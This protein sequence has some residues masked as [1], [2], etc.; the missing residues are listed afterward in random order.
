[1]S[2]HNMD[3]LTDVEENIVAVQL[4][5]SV[6][7]CSLCSSHLLLHTGAM[8]A[9][10]LDTLLLSC[11]PCQVF[12]FT[13]EM[14]VNEA[15]STLVDNID[16]SVSKCEDYIIPI[17]VGTDF[18]LLSGIVQHEVLEVIATKHVPSTFGGYSISSQFV[19]IATHTR[20]ISHPRVLRMLDKF[21][22]SMSLQNA[23]RRVAISLQECQSLVTGRQLLANVHTHLKIEHFI[24][25][26]VVAIRTHADVKLGP[27]PCSTEACIQ[28]AKAVAVLSEFNFVAPMHVIAVVFEV[29]AHRFALKDL[30]P[31]FEE[32]LVSHSAVSAEKKRILQEV[33][34]I[35]P[36]P[37]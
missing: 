28:A 8:N 17:V 29:L 27:S 4:R 6:D 18:D 16:Q 11:F 26:I 2:P 3:D 36:A 1:M 21:L 13:S 33:L 25:D 5:Q 23:E 35:A 31:D 24:R 30:D 32:P 22:L 7:I 19:F 20:P 37:I 34:E 12:E 15:L 14:T 10:E 9:V